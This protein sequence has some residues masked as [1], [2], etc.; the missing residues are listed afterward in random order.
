MPQLP[1]DVHRHSD[2]H[3]YDSE[4]DQNEFDVEQ[5]PLLY[6]DGGSGVLAV[7]RVNPAP[8]ASRAVPK[9][10]VKVVL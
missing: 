7:G 9:V 3:G 4:E 2:T 6:V 1:L 5:S 8:G 10:V